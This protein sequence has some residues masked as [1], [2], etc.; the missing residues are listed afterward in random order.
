MPSLGGQGTAIGTIRFPAAT[1]E[2]PVT[3]ELDADQN[4]DNAGKCWRES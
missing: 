3:N 2:G 4:F 1:C